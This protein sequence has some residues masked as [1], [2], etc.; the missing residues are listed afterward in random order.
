[1]K[2]KAK[3]ISVTLQ[4]GGI[5][6]SIFAVNIASFLSTM[7]KSETTDEK[8]KVL[9]IDSDAHPQTTKYLLGAGDSNILNLFDVVINQIPIREVTIPLKYYFGKDGNKNDVYCQFDFLPSGESLKDVESYVNIDNEL[10]YKLLSAIDSVMYDYDF[11]IIDCPPETNILLKNA[12]NCTDYY[13][14][15]VIPDANCYQTLA[16]SV[17]QIKDLSTYKQGHILGCVL[18]HIK[19]NENTIMLNDEN[20][21]MKEMYANTIDMFNTVIPASKAVDNSFVQNLP[22]PFYH[23]GYRPYYYRIFNAF[24]NLVNEI[25]EKIAKY[26]KEKVNNE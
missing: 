25:L 12:F 18:N 4:K 20:I 23:R 5:G 7:S 8:Y 17:A 10:E 6:K 3:V 13:I 1:M 11:I 14:L 2:Q 26:E 21:D 9:L 15:P 16:P 19:N 22:I 24:Y